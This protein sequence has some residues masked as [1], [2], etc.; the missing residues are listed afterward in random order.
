MKLIANSI[1]A[2]QKGNSP[3][4]TEENKV[5]ARR[6]YEALNQRNLAAFEELVIPD[7][8]LHN[9]SMTI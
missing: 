6:G 4:S 3:M 5:L 8:V 1:E 9:A 7:V 2:I